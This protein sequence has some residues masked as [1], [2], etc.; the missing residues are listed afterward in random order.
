MH[1]FN[2]AKSSLKFDKSENIWACEFEKEI[3]KQMFDIC[4]FL[5]EK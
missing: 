4:Y 1:V 3:V 5:K 2:I